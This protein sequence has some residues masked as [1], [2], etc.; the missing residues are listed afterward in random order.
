V[1][2][3]K[4]A[5]GAW[6]Q[7]NAQ[8]AKNGQLGLALALPVGQSLGTGLLEMARVR[9]AA[10][11]AT[12]SAGLQLTEA[13]VVCELVDTVANPLSMGLIS[14]AVQVVSAPGFTSLQLLPGGGLQLL[15]S[16]MSGQVCRLQASTNLVDWVTLSTNVLDNAPLPIVDATAPGGKCRFYRLMP[17]Q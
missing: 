13:P 6:L 4:D 14:G 12:G 5:A 16:G 9:F 3:G 7:V 15:I 1:T 10:V 17:A 2:L 11:G 8:R